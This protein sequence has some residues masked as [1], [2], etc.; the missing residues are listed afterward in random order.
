M[1]GCAIHV[2]INKH[3]AKASVKIGNTVVFFLPLIIIGGVIGFNSSII[4]SSSPL[5]LQQQQQFQFVGS[6]FLIDIFLVSMFV[7]VIC[8]ILYFFPKAENCSWF[9][10]KV[11][12]CEI[13]RKKK[14]TNCQH[15]SLSIFSVWNAAYWFLMLDLAA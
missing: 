12:V 5:P 1:I 6:Y 14:P 3:L 11:K 9:F 7:I 8:F 13:E 15:K 2:S 4:F 10:S